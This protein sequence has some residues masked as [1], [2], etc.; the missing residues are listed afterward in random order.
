MKPV[1]GNVLLCCNCSSVVR[2]ISWH[3][4][5][6]GQL[7]H[8][9]AKSDTRIYE[10]YG[11]A[12]S[13]RLV[14]FIQDFDLPMLWENKRTSLVNSC[15]LF[16]CFTF[17]LFDQYQM[18]S[19]CAS[20]ARSYVFSYCSCLPWMRIANLREAI[21]KLIKAYQS[22]NMIIEP[23]SYALNI[24]EHALATMTLKNNMQMFNRAVGLRSP[25]A[26]RDVN[27]HSNLSGFWF[28][29]DQLDAQRWTLICIGEVQTCQGVCF[30]CRKLKVDWFWMVM[31]MQ[32]QRLEGETCRG[33][34]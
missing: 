3:S 17:L 11:P 16:E 1:G 4:T 34:N 18:E 32:V 20:T 14:A 23:P 9:V 13:S 6:E 29:G 19:L 5:V 31:V 7:S 22:F 33:S 25:K 28:L 15:Q 10:L 12:F 27:L 8:V 30:F 21:P 24:F 2:E 26:A